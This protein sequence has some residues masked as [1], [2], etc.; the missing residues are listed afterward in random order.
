MCVCV[1]ITKNANFIYECARESQVL[2]GHKRV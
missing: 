1:F 2:V